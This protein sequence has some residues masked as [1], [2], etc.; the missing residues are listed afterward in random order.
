[1]AP[2][3]PVVT[4]HRHE[5]K[6]RTLTVR[7]K[8][9]LT[10]NMIRIL[11][12]GVDLAGFVSLA[13]DDHVKLFIPTDSGEPERRDYTP[14][15]F[16]AAAATLAIDFAVHDAGPATR[17]A[18][19]AAP[20]DR[21][22]IGGPRGSAVVAPGFSWWLLVGDE[23]ALPAIGRRIEELPAGVRVVSVVAIAESGDEQR[24]A[25]AAEHEAHWVRRPLHRADDPAPLLVALRHIELPQG[26]GFVW[27]AAEASVA[28]AVRDELVGRHGHPRAWTKAA[29]YWRKGVADAHEKLQD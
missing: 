10:P 14:R 7:Q 17:W 5:L 24:F 6:R 25:T 16:D 13:P 15:L 26:D 4:R 8:T 28:R 18:I 3:E 21:L 2:T 20:G 22:D 19:G 9:R 23:T 27:I 12:E 11:F 29:G 1:M